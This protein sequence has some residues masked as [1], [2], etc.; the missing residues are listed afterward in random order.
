M[1]TV[2]VRKRGLET[3]FIIPTIGRPTLNR[4][5]RSAL[6][7]SAR[8]LVVADDRNIQLETHPSLSIVYTPTPLRSG[9][10]SRNYGVKLAE[11]PWVSFL[12]DDDAVTPDYVER[13]EECPSCDVVIFRMQHPRL[14]L[15]PKIPMIAFGNVGISFSAR[16]HWMERICFPA[17]RPQD[18]HILRGL[19]DAGARIHFSPHLTYHVRPPG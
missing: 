9:G 18:F 15:V 6:E 7:T 1:S 11:T 13:L 17:E 2:V 14:G 16:T 19:E 3:T 10:L 8:V 4:A 5:V 12:D